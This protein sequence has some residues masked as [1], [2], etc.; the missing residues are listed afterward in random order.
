[1]KKTEHL[2]DNNYNTTVQINEALPYEIFFS[3]P[4]PIR[5]NILVL[6]EDISKGQKVEAFSLWIKQGNEWQKV[7]GATTAGYK[8]ILQFD[9][10]NGKEFKVIIEAARGEVVLSHLG[11]YYNNSKK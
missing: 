5:T 2:F 3:I 7:A 8:R 1:M 9:E 4:Q 10:V 6:Q 11:L